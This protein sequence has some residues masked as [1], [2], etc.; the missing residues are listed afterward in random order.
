MILFG[1]RDGCWELL[2]KKHQ[3]KGTHSRAP[4]L[5][6]Y[7]KNMII[8]IYF[9]ILINLQYNLIN[10]FNGKGL[11]TMLR[12]IIAAAMSCALLAN[13]GMITP[14]N[15]ESVSFSASASAAETEDFPVSVETTV[16]STTAV[17][18]TTTTTTETTSLED[19]G[20]A[21]R[22]GL[23][24]K[25]RDVIYLGD[26]IDLCG[27]NKENVRVE[28]GE[29]IYVVGFNDAKQMFRVIAGESDYVGTLCL[30]YDDVKEAETYTF[31]VSHDGLVIGDLDLNARV[32][33][34]DLTRMKRKLLYGWDEDDRLL[35]TLSD[36][37]DDGE[38]SIADA[39]KLQKW[40]LCIK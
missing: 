9:D 21:I 15:T 8:T 14:A 16:V 26:R 11:N 29:S 38:V 6:L 33:A 25:V 23:K 24:V 39:I 28:A 40:L 4:F 2:S 12:K 30:S 34:C 18:E 1:C 32:N 22:Q 17:E 27:K 37:N 3:G 36:M 10:L 5:W 20:A 7:V 31:F 19:V 35:Y 13:V